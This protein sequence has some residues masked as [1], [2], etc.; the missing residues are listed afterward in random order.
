ML[1]WVAEWRRGSLETRRSR[2]RMARV[3]GGLTMWT[4]KAPRMMAAGLAVENKTKS[5]LLKSPVDTEHWPEVQLVTGTKMEK[6]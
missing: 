6:R 3:M 1:E 5:Q 2:D 4:L